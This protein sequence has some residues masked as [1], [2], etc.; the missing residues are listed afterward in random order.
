MKEDMEK[1]LEELTGEEDSSKASYDELMAAKQKEVSAA[2]AA[3]EEKTAR[4][5]EV[6][7]EIVENK[8]DLES[9]QETLAEDT[10]S[11]Q[12]LET[13][14]ATKT[15]EFEALQKTMQMEMVAL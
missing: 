9:S 11:L 3:I 5:G 2:G 6:A 12:A 10:K 7:V 14:C 8:H 4:V 15:K 1:D 13:E